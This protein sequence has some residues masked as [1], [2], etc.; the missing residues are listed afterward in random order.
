VDTAKYGTEALPFATI[1][2]A[3]DACSDRA[4]CGAVVLRGG[5]HFLESTI[6]ITPKHS[7]TKLMAYPGEAPVMSGGIKLQNVEWKPAAAPR[8]LNNSWIVT[9]DDNSVYDGHI[10]NQTYFLLGEL[11]SAVECEQAANAS[12][13]DVFTYH[14]TTVEPQ[15]RRQCWGKNGPY[16]PHKESG[17]TSGHRSSSF[18]FN[19]FVANVK[20]QIEDAPGLQL[21]GVRATRARYPN[22]PGGI[23]VSPGY[24][25]MIDGSSAKWTPPDLNKYGPVKFYTDEIPEDRRNTT[26]NWF[27]NYMIGTDGLCSVYDPP[28][29]Y[30]CSEHP[31]GGGAFAFRTPRG[32]TPGDAT[33]PNSPYADVSQAV[34]FVWRPVS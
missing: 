2:Y 14:D 28:V 32:V 21:D 17:H 12:G 27:N 19:G 6:V 5:T 26:D 13:F 23:E 8:P 25:A 1:Q 29:S 15:F 4:E 7:H 3:L 30:W 9:N 16:V 20:G 24:G 22:L 33:L 31:S 10:D 11:D 18:A 34:F